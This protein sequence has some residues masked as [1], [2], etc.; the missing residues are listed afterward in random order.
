VDELEVLAMKRALALYKLDD[1]EWGVN[2]RASQPGFSQLLEARSEERSEKR[3]ARSNAG[4]EVRSTGER[5]TVE[6]VDGG[7]A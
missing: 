7:G 4:Q 2:S 3:E 6:F 1:G 5:G